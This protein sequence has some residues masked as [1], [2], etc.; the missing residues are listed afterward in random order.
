MQSTFDVSNKAP[1]GSMSNCR[2][3]WVVGREW[4]SCVVG[5]GMGV[6]MR[7]GVGLVVGRKNT[8]PP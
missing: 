8:P 6:G 5:A 4:K 1:V 2:G 7:V 3:S